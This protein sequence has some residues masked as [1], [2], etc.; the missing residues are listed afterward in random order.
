MFSSMGLYPI[1]GQNL[2]MLTSPVFSHVE[3]DLGK[4]GKTLIIDA[5]EANSEN[6]YIRW[7][8]LN[9]L[10]IYRHWIR[11]NEIANGGRLEF[12]LT[13]IPQIIMI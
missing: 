9:G 11:H 6:I 8:K 1:M 4:S 5:P 2:Y 7:I 3:V 12:E 13:S 10:E